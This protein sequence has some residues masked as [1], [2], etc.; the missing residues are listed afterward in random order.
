MRPAYMTITR[1]QNLLT[2]F[3]SW[4]MKMRPM[5]RRVTSSSMIDRTCVR[6]VT[7]RAEVG[8]SAISRSGSRTTIMA[9]M[10]RWPMPPDNSCG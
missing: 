6:T 5:P 1:S 7:S 3:R 9:I 10:T 8:S 2:R 4:L